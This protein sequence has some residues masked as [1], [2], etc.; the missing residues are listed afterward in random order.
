MKE[1]SAGA[2]QNE[3]ETDDPS[4]E[5][6]GALAYILSF[7]GGLVGGDEILLTAH[8]ASRCRLTLLT[9]VRPP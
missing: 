1:K 9:Q 5:V 6:L 3:G 4:P 7:G 8:V 2:G